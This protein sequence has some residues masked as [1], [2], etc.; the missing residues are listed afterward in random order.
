MNDT[1]PVDGAWLFVRGSASVRIS[2]RLQRDGR[3]LLVVHGPGTELSLHECA[4]VIECVDEQMR[5]ERM[6]IGEG[7]SL[8]VFT[9]DR[10]KSQ[11]GRPPTDRRR[12]GLR[13][14]ED[15][16]TP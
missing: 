10:R 3:Y 14:V 7:F 1:L 2:R 6:L 16:E 5:V 9:S 8:D 15:V 13:L 4:N 12:S 11:G